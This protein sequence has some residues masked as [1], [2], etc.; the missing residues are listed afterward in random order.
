MLSAE[1]NIAMSE[2]KKT[3]ENS[4]F[5]Y[6]PASV[7]EYIEKL[8]AEGTAHLDEL[9]S[10]CRVLTEENERLK[11]SLSEEKVT[12]DTADERVKAFMDELKNLRDEIDAKDK[13]IMKLE[14]KLASAAEAARKLEKEKSELASETAALNAKVRDSLAAVEKSS[15]ESDTLRRKAADE[16]EVSIIEAEEKALEIIENARRKADVEAKKIIEA[17]EAEANRNLQKTRY[18]LKRQDRLKDTL[19]QHKKELDSFYEGLEK[20]FRDEEKR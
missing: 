14:E 9:E 12:A 11:N 8:N 7:I 19:L 17:A 1:R 16:A 6:K 13:K 2:E 18:L 5:G 20:N 15:S 10:K 3:F 4:F